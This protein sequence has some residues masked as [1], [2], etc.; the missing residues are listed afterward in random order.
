MT[1]LQGSIP[2]KPTLQQHFA[3]GHKSVIGL[4]NDHVFTIGDR[5]SMS[6]SFAAPVGLCGRSALGVD[7]VRCS[8]PHGVP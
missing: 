4:V 8:H 5:N 1:S 2:L 6:V 3:L 7:V